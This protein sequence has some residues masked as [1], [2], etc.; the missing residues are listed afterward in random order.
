MYGKSLYVPCKFAVNL[1]SLTNFFLKSTVL[2]GLTQLLIT[3]KLF[4]WSQC[5][6]KKFLFFKKTMFLKL[7]FGF[8]LKN[9]PNIQDNPVKYTVI[10]Q[11]FKSLDV[12]GLKKEV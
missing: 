9:K 11:V 6:T 1:K 7:C 3:R 4:N 2:S 12:L 5:S 8:D 10:W